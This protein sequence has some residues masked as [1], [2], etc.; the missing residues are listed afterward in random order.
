VTAS[1]AFGTL[2]EKPLPMATQPNHSPDVQAQHEH[3][4]Q[5]LKEFSTV[6]LGTFEQNAEQPSFA[7]RPMHVARLEADC[8]MSFLSALGPE[9]MNEAMRTQA[10]H[11]IGQ[12]K[13]RFFTMRGHVT[14]SQD[15]TR[16]RALWSPMNEIWFDGPEDPRIV[17][18]DFYPEEAELWDASGVNGLR[19]LFQAAKALV[20]GEP[21]RDAEQRAHARV[22]LD[23]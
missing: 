10:A 9:R 4:H 8:S 1:D 3:L 17:L 2:R 12:S 20:S 6:M 16:I 11:V 19:F 22:Q 13:T 7:T 15:R 5:L 18:I 21:P 14:V 23:G